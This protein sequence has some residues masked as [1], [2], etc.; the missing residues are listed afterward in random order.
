L[1]CHG[2]PDPVEPLSAGFV[3]SGGDVLDAAELLDVT[4]GASE[5]IA[6]ACSI[7]WRPD[8]IGSLDLLGDEALGL[9]AALL[10]SGVQ[11]LVVSISRVS[12]AAAA[13][14]SVA[15]HTHRRAGSSPPEALQ[16]AQIELLSDRAI[17]PS[18]WCGFVVYC[19]PFC[20]KPNIESKEK[21]A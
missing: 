16:Q 20:P 19:S 7:G 12:D 5:I 10:A 6:S 18:E 2:T 21:S 17:P 11:V 14:I 13:R 8:H 3:L 1:I 15:Y 9:P 4:V